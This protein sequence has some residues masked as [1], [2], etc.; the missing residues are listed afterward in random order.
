MLNLV[1]E[2]PNILRKYLKK[3]KKWLTEK[4][5]K[6]FKKYV[7]GLLL[8]LKRTN[9]QTI[10]AACIESKYD[11]LHHFL[12]NSPWNEEEL[13][14]ERIKIVQANRQTKSCQKGVLA[15]DD[16]SNKKSG[17]HT[18]GAQVQYSGSQRG[19]ANNN[20]VV[21]SHY[22]D[23]K[24]D[25]PINLK[26]YLPASECENGKDSKTF[27]SKLELAEKLV[28]DALVKGIEFGEVT[29]DSWYLSK[30]F[31]KFLE[32]KKLNWISTLPVDRTL[33]YE[34]K[35][36]RVDEPVKKLGSK[37]FYV[38]EGTW[39]TGQGIT[40]IRSLT[41]EVKGLKGKKKIVIK[42]KFRS[43]Y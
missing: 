39:L 4:Q 16:T 14:L 29:F 28:V 2:T 19:L 43:L 3:F 15:I 21:T 13:N 38:K 5:F 26:P 37:G 30:D 31:I 18:E 22:V 27:F 11:S 23:D 34:G 20:T 42:K 7:S 25:F 33:F 1:L 40:W 10:N 32:G 41:L 8:E 36:I 9:I 17:K 6:N 24:K 12:S 35:A